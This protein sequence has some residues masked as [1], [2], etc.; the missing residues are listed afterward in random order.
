MFCPGSVE[1]CV[2][3]AIG[4][5][6]AL[7]LVEFFRIELT[8]QDSAVCLD[9][10]EANITIIS[11]DSKW[12]FC[13]YLYLLLYWAAVYLYVPFIDVTINLE[14]SEFTIEESVGNLNVCAILSGDSEIIVVTP[15]TISD[16]NALGLFPFCWPKL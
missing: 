9:P 12:L 16:G 1:V 15:L 14:Q 13:H 8:T 6:P 10:K 3:V 2:N 7:E 5:D 11:D 4:N